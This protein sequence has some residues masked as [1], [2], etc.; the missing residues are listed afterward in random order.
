MNRP[1]I[2]EFHCL[3]RPTRD[4]LSG[5]LAASEILKGYLKMPGVTDG[6][7]IAYT[8]AFEDIRQRRQAITSREVHNGR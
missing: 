3:D 2:I 4:E 6:E 7:I 5:L 1:P 8:R